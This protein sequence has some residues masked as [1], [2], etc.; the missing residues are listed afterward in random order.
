MTIYMAKV[1]LARIPVPGPQ[2]A[3]ALFTVVLPAHSWGTIYA[4]RLWR[5][6]PAPN[7][8]IYKLSDLVLESLTS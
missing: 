2:R 3:S 6:M 5:Q 8:G 4:H 7:P 1:R